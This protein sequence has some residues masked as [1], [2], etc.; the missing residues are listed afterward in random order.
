MKPWAV[1]MRPARS[2]PEFL[3]ALALARMSV[4]RPLYPVWPSTAAMVRV[5]IKTPHAAIAG[6]IFLTGAMLLTA[7]AGFRFLA[8][9]GTPHAGWLGLV[10][11]WNWFVH[12]G[13]LSFVL[14]VPLALLAAAYR[15]ERADRWGNRER[16]VFAFLPVLF[17]GNAIPD[18]LLVV[19]VRFRGFAPVK[20]LK[21]CNCFHTL[22]EALLEYVAA[23]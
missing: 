8:A 6:K 22:I 10:L 3:K 1:A 19:I 21:L 9:A 16:I 4:A 13:F 5:T 18:I 11:V 2:R 15:M 20:F 23:I 12:M 17:I 7:Y 14:S